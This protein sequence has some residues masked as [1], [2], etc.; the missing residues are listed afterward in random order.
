METHE[1]TMATH[2]AQHAMATTLV[3]C[4]TPEEAIAAGHAASS[5]IT[6]AGAWLSAHARLSGTRQHKPQVR[7]LKQKSGPPQAASSGPEKFGKGGTQ[8]PRGNG[9]S[10]GTTTWARKTII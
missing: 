2:L 6:G 9:W 10:S 4:A 5:A 3:A 7:D 8:C 1:A